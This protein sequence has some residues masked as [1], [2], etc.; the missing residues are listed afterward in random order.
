MLIYKKKIRFSQTFAKAFT[1]T[2]MHQLDHSWCGCHT[3][4]YRNSTIDIIKI[5]QDSC[6]LHVKFLYVPRLAVFCAAF[7]CAATQMK[8][9][10]EIDVA[11]LQYLKKKGYTQ[12]EGI[13]S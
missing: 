7:H 4:L 3:A 12:A 5:N 8:D 2:G 1:A 13:C 6:H 10:V 11:V 9:P